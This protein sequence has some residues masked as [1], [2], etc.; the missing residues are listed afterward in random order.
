MIVSDRH[1]SDDLRIDEA[2]IGRDSEI[3]AAAQAGSSTAFEQLHDLYSRRLFNTICRITKNREDAE[4]ALQNTLLKTYL[5][6][7]TFE[8]RSTVYSWLTRIAVNSALMIL[9]KRRARSKIIDDLSY[10]DE[11]NTIR[12]FEVRDS[13]PDAEQVLDQRQRCQRLLQTVQN[14]NP[15]LRSV[16]Q[17]RIIHGHTMREMANDL[18]SSVAAIKAKLHR[19]RTRLAKS[20]TLGGR[21]VLSASNKA[22]LLPRNRDLKSQPLSQ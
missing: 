13:R 10:G 9:R 1:G 7:H 14:L 8:G 4:D 6:I 11:G 15:D 5:A 12:V 21:R 16:L 17:A 3:V 2:T 18:D 22:L 19:A 20:R